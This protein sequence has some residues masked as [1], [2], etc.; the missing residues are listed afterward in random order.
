MRFLINAAESTLWAQLS[1]LVFMLMFIGLIYRV[2]RPIARERYE[3]E[4]RLPLNDE[5]SKL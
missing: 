2:Y 4:A 1:S 5:D 3:N